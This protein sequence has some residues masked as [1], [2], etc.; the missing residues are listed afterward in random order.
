MDDVRFNRE[1]E[2]YMPK[3]QQNEI[4]DFLKPKCTSIRT[5]DEY[6]YKDISQINQNKEQDIKEDIKQNYKSTKSIKCG[7]PSNNE[8]L[9]G[10]NDFSEDLMSINNFDK[11]ITNDE[12]VEDNTPF[13][14]RLSRLKAD[15]D[16]ISVPKSDKI[17]FTS[18]NFED[19]YDDIE[20]TT[21]KD[22]IKKKTQNNQYEN[23]QY[24]NNQYEN[25]QYENNQYENN[26]YENNQYENNQ[27]EN[28]QYEELEYKKQ[29]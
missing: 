29:L 13:S 21:I 19:T 12:I 5:H 3:K 8:F 14:D 6:E 1:N 9:S 7:A 4:P 18:E 17:D 15:R 2:V 28:N 25:N 16:S 22:L 26:Q 24:E 11:K 10:L 27:Y 23:N 20:P